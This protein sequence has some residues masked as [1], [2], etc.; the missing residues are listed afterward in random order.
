VAVP[1]RARNLSVS[2]KKRAA[3]DCRF[4]P[5][6][7]VEERRRQYRV[8]PLSLTP[9]VEYPAD[10]PASV[11]R[12]LLPRVQGVIKR[13]ELGLDCLQAGKP[14][15]RHLFGERHS[16]RRRRKIRLVGT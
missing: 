8:G 13:L 7:S 5:P 14:D 15:L 16:T 10:A 2:I 4:P 12:S 11:E 3:R 6:W 9:P 1:Y